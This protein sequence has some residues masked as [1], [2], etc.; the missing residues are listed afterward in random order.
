M[1][2]FINAHAYSVLGA[3]QWQASYSTAGE[4]AR[5]WTTLGNGLLFPDHG[6]DDVVGALERLGRVLIHSSIDLDNRLFGPRL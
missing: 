6:G 1:E 3:W 4:T 2:N 5:E